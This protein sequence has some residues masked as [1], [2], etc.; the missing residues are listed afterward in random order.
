MIAA[1]GGRFRGIRF[2]T[3]SHPDQAVW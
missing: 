3:A 1:G 2:I